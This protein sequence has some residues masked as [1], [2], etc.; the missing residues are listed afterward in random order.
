MTDPTPTPDSPKDLPCD[1]CKAPAGS[2]CRRPSGHAVFGGGFH[3]PRRKAYA[4]A[5]RQPEG[6]TSSLGPLFD[7]LD[8][9][10]ADTR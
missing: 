1:T 3:A 4:Q 5:T 6:P 8:N 10:D 7:H 2:P 9:P